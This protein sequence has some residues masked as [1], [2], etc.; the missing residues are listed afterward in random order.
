VDLRKNRFSSREPRSS[1]EDDIEELQVM[2]E[3]LDEESAQIRD[4]YAHFG[5]AVYLAQCVEHGIVIALLYTKLIPGEHSRAK[6]GKAFSATDFERRFDVFMDKQF[7]ETMGGLIS[8]L[9]KSATLPA[10]FDIQLIK[11]KEVRNFLI[12]R[13]FRE[14]AEEFVSRTGRQAMLIELKEA[15]ELFEAVDAQLTVAVDGFKQAAGFS[16][17]KQEQLVAEYLAQAYARAEALD[18]ME[19]R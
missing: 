2:H 8:R 6:S 16:L 3:D 4:V 17:T 10:G 19:S 7:E 1:S 11:A 14:R 18:T 15:Q 12:H 5:L 13:Y 9:L